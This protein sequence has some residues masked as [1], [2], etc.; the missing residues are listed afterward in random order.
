MRG[1]GTTEKAD[2]LREGMRRWGRDQRAQAE[3]RD[4]LVRAL[5]EAGISIEEIHQA[6]GIG[7]STIDRIRKGQ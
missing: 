2:A 5:L 4:P 3:M 1:M 7:R 6:M